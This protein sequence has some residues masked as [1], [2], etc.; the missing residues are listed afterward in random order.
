MPDLQLVQNQIAGMYDGDKSHSKM[1]TATSYLAAYNSQTD[2]LGLS[3]VLG[4]S[5][6][7]GSVRLKL[8]KGRTAVLCCSLGNYNYAAI[9]SLPWR[10]VFVE[11]LFLFVKLK[12]YM[13]SN[14]KNAAFG[15]QI[16]L[17]RCGGEGKKNGIY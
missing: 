16:G 15:C 1:H 14:H 4:H 9:L 10:K 5:F 8:A 13:Y 17:T 7:R 11:V 3:G 2:R 12:C 6:N